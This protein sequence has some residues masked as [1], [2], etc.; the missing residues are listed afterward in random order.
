MQIRDDRILLQLETQL[1]LGAAGG[2]K[3][4]EDKSKGTCIKGKFPKDKTTRDFPLEQ[5]LKKPNLGKG[6]RNRMSWNVGS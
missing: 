1:P 2:S 4:V 5:D 3:G 6:S